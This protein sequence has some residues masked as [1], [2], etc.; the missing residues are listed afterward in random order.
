MIDSGVPVETL[1]PSPRLLASFSPDHA[2]PLCLNGWA[3]KLTGLAFSG[4]VVEN[5]RGMKSRSKF[6]SLPQLLC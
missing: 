1:Q 6:A 5:F 3:A 4:W 2:E